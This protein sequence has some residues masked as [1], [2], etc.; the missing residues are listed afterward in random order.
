MAAEQVA[1]KWR[2]PIGVKFEKIA[3]VERVVAQEL[4]Q[5]S[6]EF[7]G[8]R[9]RRDVDDGARILPVFGAKSRGVHLEF[10]NA[11]DRW[12]EV[13][14]AETGMIETDAVDHIVDGFLPGAGGVEGRSEERRV[15]KGCR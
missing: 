4:K 3:G 6:V 7:I 15:G 10:L 1:L 11:A 12:L 2:R 14:R 9:A 8:A 13:N 5:L